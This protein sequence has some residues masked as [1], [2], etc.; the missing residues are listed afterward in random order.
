MTVVTK[1]CWGQEEVTRDNMAFIQTIKGGIL[2]K[3]DF[4]PRRALHRLHDAYKELWRLIMN[5]AS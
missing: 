3:P 1:I 4:L 2:I 5:P